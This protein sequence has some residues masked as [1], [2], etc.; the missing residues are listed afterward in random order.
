[1]LYV[2]PASCVDCGACVG[3][4]PVG[5]IVPHTRLTDDQLP[6]L[7]INDVF[8]VAARPAEDP[9]GVSPYAPQ[10]PVLP[11]RPKTGDERLR[12]AVVGSG[13]A[14]MYTADELLKR[15]GVEVTVIDR[16]PTP[17]GLV[18]A[19]VAPD[20]PETRSVTSLFTAIEGQR[21]FGYALGLEVGTD[22]T[23]QELLDHH[24]AVVYATGAAH[25]RALGIAGESTPGSASAT[26]FVAWYNGHPDHADLDPNLATERVVIIGNGNVALDA[27]RILATDPERLATTD[28]AD[29]ALAAL[30]RSSVREVV[31][32]GRRGPAQ[33]AFTLPELVGLLGRDDIEVATEGFELDERTRALRA[34]GDLDLLTA[35]K[36]EALESLASRQSRPGA[37]RI[38][39]R[40]HAAPAAILGDGHVT[41]IR[42][43]RTRL[44]AGV[45]G[46]VRAEATGEY[47]D[48]EAG[49]VLRAIGYRGTGVIG[50]PFDEATGTVPHDA[51][52]ILDGRD[53]WRGGYV[54]GWIK[55]GPTGFIGTNKTCAQETVDALV[56]DANDGLLPTPS[57]SAAEFAA[58]VRRRCPN[59]IDLAGWRAIDAQERDRG[60][61]EGRP[62]ARI[63]D[64]DEMRQ[65]AARGRRSRSG[66]PF[67]T[68]RMGTTRSPV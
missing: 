50:V 56:S 48:V 7:D 64:P 61:A 16:L 52:R 9:G 2:D 57:G 54:A 62:R 42:V 41:G 30:R 36:L 44:V 55:R 10:A 59:V 33:A 27:A 43:E 37:R 23:H 60:R 3:A 47:D 31:L 39:L 13:P 25:D 19:G 28:I 21:G 66:G 46:V 35:R 6:F 49:L 45:D 11:I 32:L 65:V 22:V 20:H 68:R 26:E 58:L 18:R 34:S 17:Y 24:H 29:H 4:C 15:P 14:A 51:G 1:M 63:V 67:R 40:F 8:G 5:A 38:V 53:P 12:V